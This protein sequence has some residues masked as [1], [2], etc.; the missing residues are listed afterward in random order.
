MRP[1]NYDEMPITDY[2][3]RL[4]RHPVKPVYYRIRRPCFLRLQRRF[5]QVCCVRFFLLPWRRSPKH[6]K[7]LENVPKKPVSSSKSKQT[8]SKSVDP[9]SLPTVVKAISVNGQP[10]RLVELDGR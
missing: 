9:A 4:Q 3:I 8:G 5:W 2:D 10:E 7:N 1:N 6:R